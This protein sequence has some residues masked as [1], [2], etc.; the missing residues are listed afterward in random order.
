MRNPRPQ[1]VLVE[2]F[3]NPNL[4]VII[5]PMRGYRARLNNKLIRHQ[6]GALE[7]SVN[8]HYN[9]LYSYWQLLARYER[10]TGILTILDPAKL[11]RSVTTKRHYGY[12]LKAINR[13][14]LSHKKT[15]ALTHLP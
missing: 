5:N 14:G 12:L 13:F 9:Y 4:E 3:L 1:E 2:H 10:S 15:L 6:A 11:Y 8:E 7:L